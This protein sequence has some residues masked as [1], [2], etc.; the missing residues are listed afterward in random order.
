MALKDALLVA[1]LIP[2]VRS[3]GRPTPRQE[4]VG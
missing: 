3:I 1:F 4:P 2:R